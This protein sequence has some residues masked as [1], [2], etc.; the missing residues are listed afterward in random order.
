MTAAD[1][2]GPTLDVQAVIAEVKTEVGRRLADSV[3]DLAMARATTV[4]VREA[5]QAQAAQITEAVHQEVAQL[6]EQVQVLLRDVE[7]RDALISR[8]RAGSNGH[9]EDRTIRRE[10]IDSSAVG[11]DSV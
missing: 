5:A 9:S 6:R 2:A 10:V 1:Q 11:D 4:A 8:L 7:E 3:I